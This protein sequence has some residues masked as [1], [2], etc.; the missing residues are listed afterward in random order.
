MAKEDDPRPSRRLAVL[1]CQLCAAPAS[2]TLRVALELPELRLEFID[3]SEGQSC[4]ARITLNNPRA[5]NSIDETMLH[6]LNSALAKVENPANGARC[7]V[8]T[9]EGRAFCA[10]ANLA[11]TEDQPGET[12]LVQVFPAIAAPEGDKPAEVGPLSML[13]VH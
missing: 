11:A 12:T 9:G 13:T 8:L 2:A 6:S 7:L 3:V 10:G 1:C 5:L 4:I